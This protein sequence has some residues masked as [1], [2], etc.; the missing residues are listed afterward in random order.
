VRGTVSNRDAIG[1]RVWVTAGGITQVH[2]IG[3][4]SH[5]LGHSERIAHFGLGPASHVDEL[6]VVWPASGEERVLEDLAADRVI[7][8]SEPE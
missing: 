3:G 6:R 8:I 5:Y 4:S 7:V 2:E 1:A